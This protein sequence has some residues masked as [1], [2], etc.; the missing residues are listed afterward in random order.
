MLSSSAFWN[1]FFRCRGPLAVEEVEQG[2]RGPAGSGSKRVWDLDTHQLF[3]LF[4]VAVFAAGHEAV[5][6]VPVVEEVVE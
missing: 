2:L 1:M 5:G 4:A 3:E 6:G